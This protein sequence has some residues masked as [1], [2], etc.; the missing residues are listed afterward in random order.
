MLVMGSEPLY[1]CKYCSKKFYK[2]RA[3]MAHECT[4][5]V[6]SR[7]IQT[8]I[9]QMA[10]GLYKLWLEKQRRK[11]PAPE[12]FCSSAY[13]S[14]FIKF[15]RWAKETSIPDTEKYVELMVSAKI[16]PALWRRDDA[17]RIYLEHLDKKTDPYEQV[18]ISVETIMTLSEGLEIQPAEVFSKFT[19]A[20]ISELINQRRLTPWLLFCSKSFKDWINTLHEGDRKALMQ[21]IGIEYWSMRLERAP[22]V[23]K[24]VREIAQALG[25]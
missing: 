10:Y 12:G 11:P 17:Y 25:I 1:S 24:N 15:A 6:R 22:E 2:E 21:N 7:E 3:F 19:S 20:E 13:Y 18:N 9:G 16:A 23:V 5:M 8:L 4:Q 14:S